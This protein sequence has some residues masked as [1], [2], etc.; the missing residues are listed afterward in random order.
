MS[1]LSNRDIE[2]IKN[3]EG[4]SLLH[5]LEMTKFS[6]MKLS[7][8]GTLIKVELLESLK[9]LV[10]FL[11]DNS[12]PYRAIGW[13]ANFILPEN[14]NFLLIKIEFPFDKTVITPEGNNFYLPASA[15]LNVL[16]SLAT[17]YGF[18]GWEVFTGVPA[19]L[20]G[21]IAMNAGTNL[22][23][24]CEL[25]NYVDILKAGGEVERHMVKEESFSYRTNHFLNE[26]DLIIGA[27][28]FHKGIDQSIPPL[29]KEYLQKRTDSQPLREKTCGCMF[30]N[31]HFSFKNQTLTCRA[32]LYLDI[33]GMK[34]LSVGDMRISPKHANFMENRG[35]SGSDEVKQLVEKALFELELHYG[36]KF[37][38]EVHLP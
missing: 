26:G 28:I 37:E 27:E 10:L 6:T 23:E 36:V 22:G 2:F 17:K 7:S 13:G 25:I 18:S 30:K 21:A 9:K 24:I 16:T 32:G 5:D 3:L 4:V 29:I 12:L 20:G 35:R 15:P 8:K 33:M 14:P 38:T 19:S 1:L 11:K 31:L 34:G